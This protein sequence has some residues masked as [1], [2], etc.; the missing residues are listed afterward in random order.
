MSKFY[1]WPNPAFPFRLY[2]NGPN[3]RVF[4]IHNLSHNYEWLKQVKDKIKPS[5]YFFV[6]LAWALDPHLASQ[7]IKMFNELELNLSQFFVMYN[8]L[9][10][11]INGTRAG[12]RGDIINHNAF[13]DENL[14]YIEKL[15]KKYDALYIARRSEIK[16]HYLAS[17]LDNL[18]L[19]AGGQNHKNKICPIPPSVNDPSEPLDSAGIR[20]IINQS[21]VGLC[22][23]EK[24]GA[25]WSSGEYLLCGTPVVSTH[26]QGG[27]SAFY[28]PHNSV[29]SA[30]DPESIRL[31]VKAVID[32]NLQPQQI[33]KDHIE[34]QT[35]FRN[36]FKQELYQVLRRHNTPINVDEYFSHSFFNKMYKSQNIET[37]IRSFND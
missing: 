13:L 32:K 25:C 26:S 1:T 5:D 31:A 22:L 27:R 15:T 28:T 6:T 33:R 19:V 9:E 29:I 18:A 14:F 17:R 34:K 21:R 4:L 37:V 35:Y 12:L 20:K 16:R 23:S 3:C 10:E 36:L 2:F 7:A 30:D 11:K 24:E 8:D